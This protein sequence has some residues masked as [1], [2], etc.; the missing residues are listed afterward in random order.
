M[1]KGLVLAGGFP[2]I[3]LIK[4]LHARDIYVLLADYNDEP[5][6]KKYAD[7]YFQVSTLNIEV[8]EK[9]V[10]ENMVDFLI[11]ACTDQ[12]L[13]TVAYISEKLGLPCYI[14]YQ[15]GINATN[16]A[17][18]KKIFVQNGIPTAKY[19]I[20]REMDINKIEAFQYP[21]IV[22]PVDCNS[23]KGVKRVNSEEELKDAFNDAVNC[24]RTNTALIEEYIDGDEISVDVYVEDGKAHI[25]CITNIEKI[26]SKDKF[27]IFRGV[28]P[29]YISEDIKQ[30][31]YKVAQEITDAFKLQNSPMLIQLIKTANHVYVLEFSARTGGGVK[32]LQIKKA[33]GFD[34]IS[35]VVDLTL[36]IKPHYERKKAETKY[37]VNE[38]IY[39]NA[40]T[41]DHLLGFEELKDEGVIS[42]YYIFKW[43]GAKLDEIDSS[44]DRVAGFT[45]QADDKQELI[46]KHNDASGRIQVLD[47]NGKDIMR[48]DMLSALEI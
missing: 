44:S 2:Q 15:T 17:Y 14:D 45:I 43:K 21:V 18:M 7:E 41:F 13:N 12:A 30:Q 24:S 6:A 9:I 25:L 26:A 11:T 5:V 1:K 28:Y 16:K 48:H 46:R 38:F 33:T 27:I 35:A 32:Y 23:S 10:L 8:V 29:A 4:E 42:E 36:G 39:C 34:V 20:M 31:I 3:A 37:L 19:Q 22:K 47:K 40:G